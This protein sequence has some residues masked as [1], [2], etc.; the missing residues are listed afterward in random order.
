MKNKI[1]TAFK[2]N[3]KDLLKASRCD[4]YA[5]EVINETLSEINNGRYDN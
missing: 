1:I 2:D 4:D 5:Q 3:H